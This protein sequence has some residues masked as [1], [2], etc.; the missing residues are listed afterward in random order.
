[1]LI[2]HFKC[3]GSLKQDAF[4]LALNAFIIYQLEKKWK[5]FQYGSFVLLSLYLEEFFYNYIYIINVLGVNG[6]L[7]GHSKLMSKI[8]FSAKCKL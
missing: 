5:W 4:W 2:C 3:P 8:L 1:M 6:T 7:L